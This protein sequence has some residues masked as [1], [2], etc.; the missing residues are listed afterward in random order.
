MKDPI[1][2]WALELAQANGW[3]PT[4]DH[5]V[6]QHVFCQAHY[7]LDPLFWQA[8]GKGLRWGVGKCALGRNE[9]IEI[10]EGHAMDCLH[11]ILT[12]GDTEKFWDNLKPN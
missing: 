8:L 9:Y 1:P 10:W 5:Q 12:G 3:T 6:A 4:K 11:L 2:R 7:V